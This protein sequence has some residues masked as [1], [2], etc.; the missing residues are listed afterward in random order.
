MVCYAVQN[1]KNKSTGGIPGSRTGCVA[2]PVGFLFGVHIMKRIPLTRGK[3]AIVDD[4][5]YDWLMNWQWFVSPENGIWYAVRKSY[6]NGAASNV[7]MHRLITHCP[8][9]MDVDH[10]D[11]DGLNNARPNLR[12]CTRRENCQN[13]HSDD[14]SQYPGV[15]LHK[16]R[17]WRARIRNTGTET[18]LGYYPTELDAAIAYRT[19]VNEMTQNA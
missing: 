6:K 8:Q 2:T 18:H 14:S 17:W 16:G 10:L 9:G 12:I 5:D 4:R 13:R 1:I 11:G 19:A 7:R 15:D 3:F